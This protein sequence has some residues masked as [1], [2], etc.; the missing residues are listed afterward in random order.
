MRWLGSLT[1]RGRQKLGV[2]ASTAFQYHDRGDACAPASRPMAARVEATTIAV[3]PSQAGGASVED[4]LRGAHELHYPSAHC[5][6][7][8]R[9][10]NAPPHPRFLPEFL[11]SAQGRVDARWQGILYSR[12]VALS[13][14][15][16]A[17]MWSV[18]MRPAFQ[19]GHAGSIP[20]TRSSGSRPGQVINSLVLDDLHETRFRPRARCVPDLLAGFLASL[21]SWPMPAAIAWSRSRV[22]W[23]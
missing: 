3:G 19:A 14:T 15:G 1:G 7:R 11:P 6:I 17:P 2:D 9:A 8:Q 21:S 5:N 13:S 4:Y 10:P 16:T 23:R 12:V 22:A 18:G 20:V